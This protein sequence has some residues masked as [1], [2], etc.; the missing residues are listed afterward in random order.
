MKKYLLALVLL[1][2]ATALQGTAGFSPVHALDLTGKVTDATTS[3]R[4]GGVKVTL[5]TNPAKTAT[6]TDEGFTIED[7]IPPEKT[8]WFDGINV[9][10]KKDGYIT[11]TGTIYSE[12]VFKGK[13][14]ADKKW[15][16]GEVYEL[17]YGEANEEGTK[18][19]EYAKYTIIEEVTDEGETNPVPKTTKKTTYIKPV[20]SIPSI[21]Y[22]WHVNGYIWITTKDESMPNSIKVEM[23]PTPETIISGVVYFETDDGDNIPLSNAEV[24]VY[25]SDYTAV[26]YNTDKYKE[27]KNKGKEKC[28]VDLSNFHEGIEIHSR[29]RGDFCFLTGP[30]GK[31]EIRGFFD[32]NGKPKTYTITA[33][34]KTGRYMEASVSK[35]VEDKPIDNVQIVLKEK[36]ISQARED[37]LKGI[38]GFKC[39]ELLPKYLVGA[40]CNE[41]KTL[42]GDATDLAYWMQKI[43][44]K[45]AGAIAMI[46]V[47]II[48][49]NAFNMVTAA[50]DTDKISE[51]KK[52]IM[53]AI[54]GLGLTMFAYV[55][56]KTIIML[57]YTK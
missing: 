11:Q 43:G 28:P 42:Q 7:F 6:T 27:G 46:A 20:I 30:D 36:T 15:V 14:L 56:I 39:N 40:K 35:V 17:Y 21:G 16:D 37:N 45:I 24:S 22:E 57:T 31:F 54:I 25:P 51:A 10:F 26:V 2:F 19:G 13:I 44:G 29:K 4:L 50:G 33:S 32:K 5:S 41:N 23:P 1:F 9:D 47:A 53:W 8:G 18:L 3:K 49:F 34:D 38:T 48:V 55:I 52:G 12:L